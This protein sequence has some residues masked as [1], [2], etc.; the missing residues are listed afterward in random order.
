[1]IKFSI[2]IYTAV[3][4]KNNKNFGSIHIFVQYFTLII[5]VIIISTRVVFFEN[6]YDVIFSNF[7]ARKLMAAVNSQKKGPK[8]KSSND[9]NRLKFGKKSRKGLA[10]VASIP[11]PGKQSSGHAKNWG[12]SKKVDFQRSAGSCLIFVHDRSLKQHLKDF[13][14]F[15]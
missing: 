7:Q 5:I 1:M 12:E 10:C 6:N 14:S 13:K 4:T 9:R 8:T 15:H 11:V 2:T 3:C